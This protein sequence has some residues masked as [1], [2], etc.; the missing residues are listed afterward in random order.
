MPRHQIN[1]KGFLKMPWLSDG[2][3]R[4]RRCRLGVFFEIVAL[5]WYIKKDMEFIYGEGGRNRRWEAGEG[6]KEGEEGQKLFPAFGALNL[7]WIQSGRSR[8][9][10]KGSVREGQVGKPE[11]LGN[12]RRG[13]SEGCNIP[14]FVPYL[15]TEDR[16]S[17]GRVSGGGCFDLFFL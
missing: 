14:F 1:R 6:K 16:L 9:A 17:L 5:A 12:L 15:W 4:Q 8:G 11:N 13:L 10:R 2:R 7:T 3:F